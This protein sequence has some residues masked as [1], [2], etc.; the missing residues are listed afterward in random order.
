MRF[1]VGWALVF[2]A[3]SGSCCNDARSPAPLNLRT[4]VL[5]P[6]FSDTKRREIV[7]ATVDIQCED[8]L[9]LIENLSDADEVRR[10]KAAWF[11]GRSNSAAAASALWLASEVE[12]DAV[13]YDCMVASLGRMGGIAR[14]YLVRLLGDRGVSRSLLAALAQ[15]S[16]VLPKPSR[17]SR[18]EGFVTFDQGSEWWLTVGKCELGAKVPETPVRPCPKVVAK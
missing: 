2:L 4:A 14:P 13:V 11:L 10:I 5:D 7:L 8:V 1:L 3:C 12:Q 6:E 17:P 9:W 18:N 16:G 15:S